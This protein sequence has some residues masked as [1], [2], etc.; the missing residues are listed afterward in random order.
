MKKSVCVWGEKKNICF[1]QQRRDGTEN[2][3][4]MCAAVEPLEND[5]KMS[6]LGD[7]LHIPGGV[8]DMVSE[9]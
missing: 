5:G 2:A 3:K 1:I 8:G 7:A 6:A 4:W 9:G